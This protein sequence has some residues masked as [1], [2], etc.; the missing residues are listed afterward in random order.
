MMRVALDILWAFLFWGGIVA[1]FVA[2]MAAG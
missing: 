2:I 1:V